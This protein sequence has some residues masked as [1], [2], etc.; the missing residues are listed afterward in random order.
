MP[1]LIRNP[2]GR[3]SHD[4][5]VVFSTSIGRALPSG[6]DGAFASPDELL[7][8]LDA[9]LADQDLCL[10]QD[11]YMAQTVPAVREPIATGL[12]VLAQVR[13]RLLRISQDGQATLQEV[14]DTLE[15][16]AQSV[17]LA[18]Q[19]T[20]GN[21]LSS[22]TRTVLH[23]VAAH[24]Q[25]ANA[26]LAPALTGYQRS[27]DGHTAKEQG[28]GQ[29]LGTTAVLLKE[30]KATEDVEPTALIA[31]TVVIP[32][33][34]VYQLYHE[35]LPAERM[36]VVAGR[37]GIDGMVTLGAAFDVTGPASWTH[38]RADPEK[39]A[40]ALMAM[41]FSGTHLAAWIHSHPGT[42]GEGTRPSPIDT[43]QHADWIRVYTPH[44]VSGILAEG[45]WLRL[46]GTAVEQGAIQIDLTGTGINKEDTHVYRLTF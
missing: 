25:E 12:L 46:W 6:S 1:Q 39:L 7:A 26:Q 16:L 21:P 13:D 33:D 40:R 22:S 42:G 18:I 14:S 36:A 27:H 15:D 45:G 2:F 41:E 28:W 3:R 5:A 20:W 43:D 4:P 32:S 24:L 8:N 37:E 31:P 10:I 17:D 29:S 19:R 11:T 38:V 23:R 9:V 35:L 30:R 34:L 44:L